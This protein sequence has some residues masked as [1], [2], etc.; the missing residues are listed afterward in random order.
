[1]IRGRWRRLGAA[2]IGVP[3]LWLCLS[4]V[5]AAH[6]TVQPTKAAAGSETVF[7]FR[8]P[9]ERDDANTVKIVLA[10]PT[11]PPIPAV[12]VEPLPGWTGH[13]RMRS[14][15]K[16]VQTDD[17]P[18]R[19]TAARITWVCADQVDAIKP[20][21][22]QQ[23]TIEAGPLPRTKRLVFKVLQFYSDGRVVRWIDPPTSG[24]EAEHPAPTVTLGAATDATAAARQR[25]SAAAGSDD[26]TGWI[27]VAAFVAGLL[28]LAAGT[29]ALVVT[30][31]SRTGASP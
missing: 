26:G 16:P 19:R 13:V 14:L 11:S 8:V 5:A 31:R 7:T 21:Q 10:L 24:A 25:P 17:G 1:M 2:V 9:T 22:F 28:G 6:V 15:A 27:A 20:G 12:S 29:T 23:F 30:R 3:I 18:V 4:G